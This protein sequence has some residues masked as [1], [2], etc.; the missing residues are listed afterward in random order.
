MFREK[1]CFIIKSSLRY[2]KKEKEY[3]HM[4]KF[5]DLRLSSTVVRKKL[6][7]Q[8]PFDIPLKT[9]IALIGIVFPFLGAYAFINSWTRPLTNYL[10]KYHDVVQLSA[11]T[12]LTFYVNAIIIIR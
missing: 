2:N 7:D 6:S 9:K 12:I 8:I 3:K 5:D 4:K 11:F 1:L 10:N